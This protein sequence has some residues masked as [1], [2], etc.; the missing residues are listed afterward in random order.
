MYFLH[1][2]RRATLCKLIDQAVRHGNT[3]KQT[4]DVLKEIRW[5]YDNAHLTEQDK[6]DLMM[7]RSKL[8]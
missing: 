3:S 7:L 1:D 5:V 4:R 6:A 8:N 2:V